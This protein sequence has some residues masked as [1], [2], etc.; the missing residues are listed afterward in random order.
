MSYPIYDNIELEFANRNGDNETS[1]FAEFI[2]NL[3]TNHQLQHETEI[4]VAK[5]IDDNGTKGLTHK[6][7]KVLEIIVDKF[8]RLQCNRCQTQI[9]WAELAKAHDNGGFCSY[10][11]D[12]ISKDEY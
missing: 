2:S 5:Y 12:K 1:G 11:S 7:G 8:V 10:C 3:L 4:G 6:Q 9:E